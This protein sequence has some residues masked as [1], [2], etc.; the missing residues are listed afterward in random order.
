ML[1]KIRG[2]AVTAKEVGAIT[3][4]VGAT[5]IPLD[6]IKAICGK[7]LEK[8][9]IDIKIPGL[10]ILDTPGHEAFTSIRKRGSSI[11]DLAILVIDIN[12]GF[13][14][15]TDESL[16]FLK[17]FKTPFIVAATKIDKMAGWVAHKGA[18]FFESYKMQPEHAKE[19][20]EKGVYRLIGQLSERG[21][22]SERYDRVKDFKKQVAIVPCSG[23]TGEGIPE[24]LVML[25][26]LAQT[27]LK[28]EL[29]IKTGEGKG[30]VLEIKEVRGLGIT[31][32]VILYD[33]EVHKGDWLV[34]GGH[35]PFVTKIRALLKPKPLREIRVEKEFEHVDS[36][37]AAAGIKIF[38]PGLEK[39]I[40]GSPIRAV[41][42]EEDVELAKKELASEVEAVEFEKAIEGVVLRADTLGSL[43]ALVHMV[44]NKGIAIK[45]AEVGPPSRKDIME[46]DSVQDRLKR[47][48][49]A[50][51]VPIAIDVEREAKDRNI[52]I[53]KS[54]VIYKLFEEYDKWIE[55][56]TAK[57]RMEKLEKIT[58]PGKVKILRGFVFRASNP[59]VIGVEVLAG[60]IKPGVTMLK[61]GKEVGTIK[62][63]QSEGVTKDKATKGERVAISMPEPTVGRQIK[64]GDE[65]VTAI[66]EKDLKV[67]EELGM[68]EEV[69]LAREIL[70]KC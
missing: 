62:E 58:L 30:S 17:E 34:I 8:F 50:F 63:I 64:E 41:R 27:F 45:K 51:N 1:D 29:E 60:Q 7:L 42:K 23:I 65:L 53:I 59:A 25:A 32:D 19:E 37:T 47:V 5:I 36:V 70:G 52:K 68:K 15:Q 43:E 33:G 4:A 44:Q 55:E 40:A 28:T 46:L 39:V 38:A 48:I 21:F 24:L 18:C 10:L 12:E 20:L 16:N 13:K 67:L 14:P 66:T 61:Q 57:I 9:K 69:M 56:Q 49:L 22:E 3:Q 11:A 26:G 31:A 2:T 54:D 35:E 6:T